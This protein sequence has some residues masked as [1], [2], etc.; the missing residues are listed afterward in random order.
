MTCHKGKRRAQPDVSA[1]YGGAYG[2]MRDISGERT[3]GGG[4]RVDM[5]T[6]KFYTHGGEGGGKASIGLL[7]AVVG[8]I[9]EARHE[10]AILLVV[11]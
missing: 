1:A 9:V 10:S 7:T 3:R 6:Q 11:A 5:G 8:G 2:P 4:A